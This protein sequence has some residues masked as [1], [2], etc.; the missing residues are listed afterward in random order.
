MLTRESLYRTGP[1]PRRVEF[2]DVGDDSYNCYVR[3]LRLGETTELYRKIDAMEEERLAIA[4]ELVYFCCDESGNSL[5][6]QNDVH[7]LATHMD[8]AR[9]MEIAAAGRRL[10]RLDTSEAMDDARADFT[11]TQSA[12]GNS[13]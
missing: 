11:T 7:M 12:V 2:V 9:A 10:T 13:A 5:F 8:A 6:N 3:T 1:A 4:L